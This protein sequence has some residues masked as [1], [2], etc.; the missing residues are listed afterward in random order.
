MSINHN[1]HK[2]IISKIKKEKYRFLFMKNSVSCIE[3]YITKSH[4][5]SATKSYDVNKNNV[6]Y[7]KSGSIDTFNSKAIK[8]VRYSIIKTKTDVLN[9]KSNCLSYIDTEYLIKSILE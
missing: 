7:V 9:K 8:P 4:S 3:G 1:L 2:T 5:E 6:C